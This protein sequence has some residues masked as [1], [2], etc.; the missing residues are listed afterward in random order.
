[1]IE[2][3]AAEVAKK[4]KKAKKTRITKEV[5]RLQKVYGNIPDALIEPAQGLIKR[6]AY[7][8]VT[9]E[10]YETDLDAGGY[11]EKF[12]QSEKTAA[13]ERERPV[14]RLYNTMNKNYQS[15]MKQLSD[16][17]PKPEPGGGGGDG[18]DGFDAFVNRKNQ[19]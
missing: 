9:L 7:M 18:D 4:A 12:T 6:A 8:L 1:M 2:Q 10:D 17:L 13:Y 11:V 19:I 15:I 3:I 14:A 16:M 5:N